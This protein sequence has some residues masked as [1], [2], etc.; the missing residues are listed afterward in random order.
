MGTLFR[1]VT[2][3]GAYSRRSRN[4]ANV[5]VFVID[6][7]ATAPASLAPPALSYRPRPRCTCSPS[8]VAV[9]RLG[10]HR[11]RAA[12]VGELG[13]AVGAVLQGDVANRDRI[14]GQIADRRRRDRRTEGAARVERVVTPNIGP[15]RLRPGDG[16]IGK[17][18]IQVRTP[19]RRMEIMLTGWLFQQKTLACRTGALSA[20]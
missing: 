10:R 18:A 9:L 17:R 5:W 19:D 1:N 15:H 16:A 7:P 20:F 3:N 4:C 12:G 2:R 8:R 14:D 13:D 6:V 11:R